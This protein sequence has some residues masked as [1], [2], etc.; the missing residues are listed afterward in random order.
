MQ[1]GE[2]KQEQ[3]SSGIIISSISCNTGVKTDVYEEPSM[4][5]ALLLVLQKFRKSG[6]QS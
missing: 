5:Q 1:S 2:Q 6:Q 4:C 3:A